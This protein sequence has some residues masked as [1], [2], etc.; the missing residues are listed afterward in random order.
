MSEYRPL[1]N[2][3]F[4]I[5]PDVSALVQVPRDLTKKEA[6]R[7]AAMILTLVRPRK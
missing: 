4:P 2:V 1:L 5:R 7:L 6:D 3:E